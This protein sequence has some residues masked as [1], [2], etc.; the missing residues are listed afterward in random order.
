LADDVTE[1][2]AEQLGVVAAQLLAVLADDL[3]MD[4]WLSHPVS[5]LGRARRRPLTATYA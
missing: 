5:L 3:E 4:N 2:P 1:L